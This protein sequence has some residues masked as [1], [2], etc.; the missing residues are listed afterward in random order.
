MEITIP[1]IK[2]KFEEFNQQMFA[3]KLP[4]LPIKLSD[5]KTF[6]GVCTYKK[7][8]GKDGK[9][10]KYDFALRVNTRIELSEDEIEDTIIHEMIHYYIGYNQLEDTS[11]H[12]AIFQ[13]VMNAINEKYGRHLSISHKSSKSQKEQAVD[14]KQHYRVVAVVRFHDGRKG[15]KV[16]PRVLPSILKYYNSVL[17]AKEVSSITLYMSNDIF[18]NRFPNSCSFKVHFLDENEIMK[19]LEGAEQMKCDG[20]LIL[21]NK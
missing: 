2:H 20:K 21:R 4:M 3:G 13:Q 6:L 5:A 18:F 15:I 12:G 11:A 8:I 16:L 14:K 7:R 17:S 10:E 9:V 1:Y 19:H